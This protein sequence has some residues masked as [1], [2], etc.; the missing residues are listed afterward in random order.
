MSKIEDEFSHLP[1]ARR[2]YLRK[3][4]KGALHDLKCT[5]C[6]APKH[7]LGSSA[8]VCRACYVLRADL[9]KAKSPKEIEAAF[10]K[11]IQT[12]SNEKS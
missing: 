10:L 7:S 6:G 5:V 8:G 11:K 4:A 1:K 12:K 3:K 2:Q 9:K